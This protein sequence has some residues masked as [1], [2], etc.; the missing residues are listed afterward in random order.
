MTRRGL[1]TVSFYLG[2]VQWRVGVSHMNE[3]KSL[4]FEVI[5]HKLTSPA[6]H[7]R[8]LHSLPG[9]DIASERI[10]GRQNL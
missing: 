10:G 4:F 5:I 6:F 2:G 3:F 8:A 1:G 9:Q 7:S